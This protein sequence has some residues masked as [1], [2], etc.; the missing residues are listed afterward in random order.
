[1]KYS[2]H[3]GHVMSQQGSCH[4]NYFLIIF[5]QH[6]KFDSIVLQTDKDIETRT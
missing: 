6:A 3:S 4:G 2:V 1:M 5:Y